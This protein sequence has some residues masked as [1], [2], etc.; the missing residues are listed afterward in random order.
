MANDFVVLK[1]FGVNWQKD[2]I[3]NFKRLLQKKVSALK[4]AEKEKTQDA[5]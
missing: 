1:K 3:D 2:Y 4:N 5:P